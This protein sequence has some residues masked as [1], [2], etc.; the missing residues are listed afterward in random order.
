MTVFADFFDGESAVVRRM[1]VT[2]EPAHARPRA[3]RGRE[4]P[5]AA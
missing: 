4:F 3:R 5:L 1:A 2:L